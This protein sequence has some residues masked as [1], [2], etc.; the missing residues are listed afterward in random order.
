M[1]SEKAAATN[2]VEWFDLNPH[3]KG[4]SNLCSLIIDP[5]WRENPSMLNFSWKCQC[6]VCLTARRISHI[7]VP[8]P[9]S[10]ICNLTDSGRH[11]TRPN[12]G[13][14]ENPGDEIVVNFPSHHQISIVSP[15]P[16]LLCSLISLTKIM[17]RYCWAILSHNRVSASTTYINQW[18]PF[19]AVRQP[20]NIAK[21]L[22]ISTE[23]TKR[24]K[25]RKN[26]HE[27][28]FRCI[29]WTSIQHCNYLET[30]LLKGE[31]YWNWRKKSL[32]TR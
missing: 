20:I 15:P 14:T 27:R 29:D 17:K 26:M 10:S 6:T 19:I 30:A 7:S 25:A 3:W 9:K 5:Y 24:G 2:S 18:I 28:W 31:V 21:R 11:M 12:Q 22:S 4:L 1:K 16:F 13:F 23:Q 32:Q 8:P